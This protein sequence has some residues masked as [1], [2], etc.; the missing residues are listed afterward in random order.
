MLTTKEQLVLDELISCNFSDA[1]DEPKISDTIADI[2]KR[3]LELI[4][5]SLENKGLIKLKPYVDG[6]YHISL[7]YDGLSYKEVMATSSTPT[8][9]NNF[10]APINNSAVA[11]SGNIS[12]NNGTDFQAIR[13]YIQQQSISPEEKEKLNEVVTYVETLIENEVPLKKNILSKFGDILSKHS[14]IATLLIK[15]ILIY[16]TGLKL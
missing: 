11:N 7:T 6:G 8:T 1:P 9:I 10:Y 15:V 14:S 3:E 2:P 16:L 12:I 4:F 13:E 5:Q